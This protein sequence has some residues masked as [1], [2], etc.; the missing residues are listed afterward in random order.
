MPVARP[1]EAGGP[2]ALPARPGTPRRRP[3]RKLPQAQQMRLPIQ[4][5]GAPGP[6][7]LTASVRH[8][9][10]AGQAPAVQPETW[11]EI[12][13]L[14]QPCALPAGSGFAGE[15]HCHRRCH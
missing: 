2:P 7:M 10:T 8:L 1:R 12:L 9:Q 15:G 3:V 4:P 6:S 11:P 5:A 13:V 14:V